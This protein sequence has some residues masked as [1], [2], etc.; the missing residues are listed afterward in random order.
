MFIC[1]KIINLFTCVE[2]IIKLEVQSSKKYHSSQSA[3]NLSIYQSIFKNFSLKT[4]LSKNP[5]QIIFLKSCSLKN[6]FQNEFLKVWLLKKINSKKYV[7]KIAP[8]KNTFSKIAHVIL[9]F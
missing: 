5:F 3:A 2:E 8:S 7:L 9:W 1:V 4:A 6:K